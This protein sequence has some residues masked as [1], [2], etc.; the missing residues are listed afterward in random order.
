[1]RVVTFD[2]KPVKK[3]NRT[4]DGQIKVVFYDSPPQTVSVTDWQARSQ[5]QFY[6]DGVRRAD[7]VRK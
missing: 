6:P 5:S 1:M 3:Q 4:A 7:V 2:G